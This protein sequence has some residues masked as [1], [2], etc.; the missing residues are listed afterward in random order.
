VKAP[1]LVQEKIYSKKAK[2]VKETF[3]LLP[4]D[5]Q[6][7]AEKNMLLEKL[8]TLWN[9]QLPNVYYYLRKLE[10]RNLILTKEKTL[11]RKVYIKVR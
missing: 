5:S 9:A 6:G 3:R 7:F 8:S 11:G 1:Q 4:K 10:A 2:Q